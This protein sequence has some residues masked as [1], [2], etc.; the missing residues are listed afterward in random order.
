MCSIA[1]HARRAACPHSTAAERLTNQTAVSASTLCRQ[2]A[3]RQDAPS[4]A[5]ASQ[6]CPV[7]FN[8]MWLFI[9]KNPR[10]SLRCLQLLDLSR[11]GCKYVADVS[12]HAARRTR[13][14][15]PARSSQLPAAVRRAVYCSRHH[16]SPCLHPR[17]HQAAEPPPASAA[18]T[19]RYPDTEIGCGDCES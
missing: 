8:R 19:A 12:M 7:A 3:G 13:R 5:L 18:A 17:P 14:R 2:Q 6:F 4:L 9:C 15:T 16:R 11:I 1:A 10:K